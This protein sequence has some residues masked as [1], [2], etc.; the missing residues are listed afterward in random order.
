MAAGCQSLPSDAKNVTFDNF[1]MSQR[2]T[3]V[4]QA[5]LK[6]FLS[7]WDCMWVER[8]GKGLAFW[9][10][11]SSERASSRCWKN[12][13]WIEG[14]GKPSD[15]HSRTTPIPSQWLFENLLS[16]RCQNHPLKIS[17]EGNNVKHPLFGAS[18]ADLEIN[19]ATSITL[20]RF[21]LV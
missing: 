14:F 19:S 5:A 6:D 11:A 10:L 8:R 7:L 13:N 4:R 1:S 17:S 20:C 3:K 18:F 9:D 15:K 16:T 12:A 2:N 21:L